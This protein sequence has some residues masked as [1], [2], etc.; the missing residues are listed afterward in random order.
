[1]AYKECP[2]AS[3]KMKTC[4]LK[5][6]IKVGSIK[7]LEVSFFKK[8]SL[9]KISHFPCNHQGSENAVQTVISNYRQVHPRG[10]DLTENY[11]SHQLI[12]TFR[13]SFDKVPEMEC[14][15]M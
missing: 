8:Q 9:T 12:E 6:Q 7:N 15:L 10:A 4:D 5:I 13:W 11:G 14:S 3:I 2:T 1:M